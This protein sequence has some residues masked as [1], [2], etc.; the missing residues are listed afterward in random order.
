MLPLSD[1]FLVPP[2]NLVPP[3]PLL[4]NPRH[5]LVHCGVVA[6]P[7]AWNVDG[8]APRAGTYAVG[9]GR[10]LYGAI[11]DAPGCGRASA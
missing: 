3:L 10:R 9:T 6:D 5:G 4:Y 8:I 7:V 1:Y 2:P 11:G